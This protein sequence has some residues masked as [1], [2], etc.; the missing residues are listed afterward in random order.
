[1]GSMPSSA[2]GTAADPAR[3]TTTETRTSLYLQ[4]LPDSLTRDRLLEVMDFEGFSGQYDFVYMPAG[5]TTG[6]AFGYAFL[7]MVTSAAAR[8]FLAHFQGFDRW[9]MPNSSA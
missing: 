4:G 3:V 1:M 5:L 8:D 7:N 2:S 9:G 6:I